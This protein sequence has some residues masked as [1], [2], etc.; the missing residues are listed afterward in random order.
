MTKD[1]AKAA[2]A[3]A[4]TG[5]AMLAAT[6]GSLPAQ[7]LRPAG[8]GAP[9]QA[10]RPAG[11]DAPTHGQMHEMMDAMH[12]KGADRRMHKAMGPEGEKM[13]DQCV[14]MMGMMNNMQGTMGSGP[15]GRMDGGSMRD[16]MNGMMGR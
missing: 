13:M 5:L 6:A 10:Q 7:A 8:G 11:G 15:S 9:T 3:G 12:G 1:Q 14:S 4:L 16:M 2:I